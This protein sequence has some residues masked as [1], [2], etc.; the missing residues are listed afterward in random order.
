MKQI[1]ITISKIYLNRLGSLM[2]SLRK[3]GVTITNYYE[4]GVIVGYA[5][6]EIIPRI[7]NHKEIVALTEE[8]QVGIPPP[9]SDIQ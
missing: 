9:D 8:K 4:F 7:R 2:E 1:V 5:E 6:E 3:E